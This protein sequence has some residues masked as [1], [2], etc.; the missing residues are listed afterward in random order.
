MI[1]TANLVI[2]GNITT[3]WDIVSDVANWPAW[4]PHEEGAR[5][6]GPFVAGTKGWSKPRK[7]PATDWLLTKVE[8]QHL[9]ASQS[10]IP[11]GTIAGQSTFEPLG[12]GSVRC[13]KVVQVQGTL[14]PL[15]W[16]YFKRPV[17]HDLH[18]SLK[19]LQNEVARRENTRNVGLQ[20]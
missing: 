5:L 7:G 16:L 10:H 2:K 19:A 15:F 11:G 4:D 8:P 20:R 17:Q 6:D 9:W 18:Q 3:I 12:N 13:T 14:V 1:I